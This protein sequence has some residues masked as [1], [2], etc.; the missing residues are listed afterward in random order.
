MSLR[1]YVITLHNFEDLDDFYN[2]METPGGN[3]YIP[4]R[5]VDVAAR[6][7]VSRNTHYYITEEEA[8]QIKA[9]PR[10][11]HVELS[12][13]EQGL[14][15]KPLWTESS[16]LYNKSST[17]SASHRNWAILRCIEGAQRA[18]WGLDSV[19]NQ[20]GTVKTTSS[21]RH[22]DIVIVDGHMDPAHPE[23]AVNPDG[24]GGSRVNQFN[25][26]SLDPYVGDS[27]MGGTYIYTP[28]Y[29]AG[30]PDLSG[31]NNHGCHVAGTAAG[32]SYGWARDANIYNITPYASGATYVSNFMDYIRE[33]HKRK[34][35]NPITGIKNPTITNHSYGISYAFPYTD[36]QQVRFN[37][38]VYNGPFTI[39]ALQ[40]YNI[41]ING[42]DVEYP[43]RYAPLEQ[44]FIDAMNDGIIVIGASG[45]EY[46]KIATPSVDLNNEYNNY[47][48]DGVYYDNYL[49][50]SITAAPRMICV[51][52]IGVISTE[53]KSTF[54]NCGPRVDI[55]APGSGI[56]SSINSPV[57]T[58]DLRNSTYKV[59]KYSGTSMASPQVCGVVACLAEQWP[60]MKQDN[61]MN[62]LIQHS[63]PQVGSTNG[64]PGDNTDTQGSP[65]RYLFYFK[66]RPEAGQV[67]PKIN[68]G[69]RPSGGQVW[70]RPKIFRYGR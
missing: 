8:A 4:G 14:K 37:G 50:G 48:Y 20:T 7:P 29:D 59:S 27:G 12:L 19:T 5:R 36:V 60:T 31:D 1:E 51:G 17:L 47:V 68:Q 40:G 44:D 28:Y 45:N 55:H 54:S 65:N 46:S 52:S 39:A 41:P 21:G 53:W 9:D 25:W 3:L 34:P 22:V 16:S 24:S 38:N 2:D 67:G 69:A 32:N 35:V 15:I 13:E 66:D 18:N 49:R 63:K 26:F 58:S 64:G 30:D 10:V 61:V 42:T 11:M 6:R 56:I 43:L 62:Y 23:F 70:P 33:W 57:G